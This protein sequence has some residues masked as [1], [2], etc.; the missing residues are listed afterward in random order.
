LRRTDIR[1]RNRVRSSLTRSAHRQE[2]PEASFAQSGPQ[3][4]IFHSKRLSTPHSKQVLRTV[5]P[6]MGVLVLMVDGVAG[7]G[8]LQRDGDHGRSQIKSTFKDER[9]KNQRPP[10]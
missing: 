3:D 6:G 10:Q 5:S 4:L 9:T 8:A 7:L 1:A 2:I